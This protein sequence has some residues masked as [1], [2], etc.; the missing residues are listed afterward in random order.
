MEGTSA[1]RSASAAAEAPPP[2][3]DFE[4]ARD[5]LIQFVLKFDR[6]INIIIEEFKSFAEAK[7]TFIFR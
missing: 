1:Y 4:V 5:D 3:V 7:N 2:G 6:V